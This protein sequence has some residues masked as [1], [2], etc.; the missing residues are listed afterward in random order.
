MK[1]IKPL[2]FL[3]AIPFLLVR[4][5]IEH[6]K[7]ERENKGKTQQKGRKNHDLLVVMDTER[8]R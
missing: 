3:F 6:S 2:L 7:M 4:M 8:K 5:K 1:Y